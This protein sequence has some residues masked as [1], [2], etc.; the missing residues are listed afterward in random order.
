MNYSLRKNNYEDF[1]SQLNNLLNFDL[2]FKE[3]NSFEIEEQKSI[4]KDWEEK[5][6]NTLIENINPKPECLIDIFK[7]QKNSIID[8]FEFGY[9]NNKPLEKGKLRLEKRLEKRKLNL[10]KI[11]DYV[12]I[13]N[14]LIGL[15]QKLLIDIQEKVDFVLEKLKILFND[16]FYSITT[17][18]VLNSIEHRNDEPEEISEILYK[19]GYII[20]KE[21]YMTTD[22]V[23]ISIKGAS[24]I[25]RKIKTKRK[26]KANSNLNSKID[27]I[28]AKLNELG[29]GQEVIFNELEEL[30]DLQNKLP[31]KTWGQLLK[32]KLLDLALA[33]IISK[34][35]ATYIFENLT[36][37]HFKLL[38]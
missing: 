16:N 37:E 34:E 9:R 38:K 7:Y 1:E 18:F 13:T 14:N 19:R 36:S 10:N 28:I 20:K 3:V 27:K 2:I 31:K 26:Q 30:R 35:T 32:G 6:E 24:Y 33:E 15:E 4:L 17:I 21:K 29:F 25:E 8:D 12:S 11:L 5:V 23:K 22:E